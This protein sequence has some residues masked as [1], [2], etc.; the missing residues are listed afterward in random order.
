MVGWNSPHQGDTSNTI[1]T[2]I[3]SSSIGI[4]ISSVGVGIGVVVVVLI[5]VLVVA[6]IFIG[7]TKAQVDETR[8]EVVHFLFGDGT[9]GEGGRSAPAFLAC[10]C[11]DLDRCVDH[12]GEVF[13]TAPI[14]ISIL[15]T[16][17]T[18]LFAVFVFVAVV[19]SSFLVLVRN[20][21]IGIS[22]HQIALVEAQ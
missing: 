12:T 20:V 21:F 22:P 9:D 7:I 16:T 15:A 2:V 8:G 11:R 18:A 17:P 3:A 13:D 1:T 6:V 5:S 19:V 10:A 4:D 14:G